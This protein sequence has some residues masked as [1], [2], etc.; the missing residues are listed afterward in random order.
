MALEEGASAAPEGRKVPI[1]AMTAK[2]F[3]EDVQASLEAGMNGHI[4]K[5]ID[6]AELMRV[7]AEYLR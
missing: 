2:A 1:I 6:V 7:L 3:Q 5:P 4:A